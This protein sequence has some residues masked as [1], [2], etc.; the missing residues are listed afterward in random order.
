MPLVVVRIGRKELPSPVLRWRDGAWAP[1]RSRRRSRK[2]IQW[3]QKRRKTVDPV[4]QESPTDLNFT[5][6]EWVEKTP[7]ILMNT[8]SS[9]EVEQWKR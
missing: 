3:T 1:C 2:R 7:P 5:W 9:G 6:W 4:G 8:H